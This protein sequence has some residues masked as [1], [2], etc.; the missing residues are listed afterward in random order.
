MEA[1]RCAKRELRELPKAAAQASNAIGRI[2]IHT[3]LA[4]VQ[5]CTR[6]GAWGACQASSADTV[7]A[8]I[9]VY[10]SSIATDFPKV[11]LDTVRAVRTTRLGPSPCRAVSQAL[12]LSD[13]A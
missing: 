4:P 11:A 13:F 6:L 5:I 7:A 1:S 12:S 2:L 3:L 10:D 8:D 9:S